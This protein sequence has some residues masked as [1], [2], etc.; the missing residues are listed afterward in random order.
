MKK[1]IWVFVLALCMLFSFG[2][3][4]QAEE[5]G[6]VVLDHAN[7]GVEGIDWVALMDEEDFQPATC[8][9]DGFI[10]KHCSVCGVYVQNEVLPKMEHVYVEDPAVA[11]TC[12][13]T[14]LT[15]GK[16]CHNEILDAE[17]N[18]IGTCGAL[19]KPE[20]AQEVVPALGH[21]PVAA[22]PNWKPENFDCEEGFSTSAVCDVCGEE[23]AEAIF[24][25]FEHQP[26]VLEAVEPTCTSTGLTEG[27]YCTVCGK[28]L[29]E[30]EEIEMLEHDWVFVP[31]TAGSCT[32]DA[33]SY[34][35]ECSVCGAKDKDYTVLPAPGHKTEIVEGYEATCFEDGLTDGE[36]CTVC[37]EWI[38]EQTV[39]PAHNHENDT[40]WETVLGTP[41]TCTEA[42]I[43]AHRRCSLCG[44][45][46][47]NG[48]EFEGDKAAEAVIIP[49]HG[50]V[51]EDGYENA[52]AVGKPAQRREGDA[53]LLVKTNPDDE[54]EATC[55][56][57]G[58]VS[59]LE[60][61]W[62]GAERVPAEE[63]EAT[64]H[65]WVKIQ[66]GI[67][68]TCTEA[69]VSDLWECE[70]CGEQH[71]NEPVNPRGHDMVTVAGQ[72]ATCEE[73]GNY[74]YAY[75]DRVGCCYAE[76]TELDVGIM[77]DIPAF[78]VEKDEDNK[79]IEHPAAVVIPAHNH[80]YAADVTEYTFEGSTVVAKIAPV[81]P[82]CN[83]TGLSDNGF[84]C[85]LCG[86]VLVPADV[87][88]T[89]EHNWV[90]VPAVD[91]TCYA[92]GNLHFM[93]CAY[94]GCTL[95][96]ILNEDGDQVDEL[97]VT[98][99]EENVCEEYP[100]EVILPAFN[101]KD[102]KPGT[103]KAPTCTEAGWTDGLYCT[104]C[105]FPLEAQEEIPALG[106]TEEEIPAVAPTCTETGLTAGV[107]CTVCEEILVEQEEVPALGHT[108]DEYRPAVAPTCTSVGY[109][110][111]LCCSVCEPDYVA[112]T[113]W[114]IFPEEIPMLEHE[115][116]YE[117]NLTADPTCEEDGYDNY[118]YC[119]N[120]DYV[121]GEIIPAL[122]HDWLTFDEEA[123]TC[124]E[125]GVISARTCSVCGYTQPQQKVDPL[126]HNPVVVPGKAA[127]CTETG[128]TDGEK[129]DRCGLVSVEQEEIPALGH[130]MVHVDAVEPTCEAAG[131]KEGQ[132][133]SNEGCDYKIGCETIE[134]LAHTLGDWVVEIQP[135]V[136]ADGQGLKVKYCLTCGHKIEA[137]M[138]P[139]LS[140][141]QLG[142]ANNDGAVNIIDVLVILQHCSEIPVGS[143]NE[144]QAD[145]NEDGVVNVLD[146]LAL[147]YAV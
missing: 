27:S 81:A 51:D 83:K 132:K 145:Y 109:T 118:N 42:G 49:A 102:T 80:G 15:A 46:E 108:Y 134:K 91:A 88:D 53:S 26:E 116:F 65:K 34:H 123:P 96:V 8:E 95:G 105:G 121:E 119:V 57:A 133:C 41:A 93:Y 90:D 98:K 135:S 38:V 31:A 4:A 2:L 18:V 111:G 131:N 78:T 40:A 56:E 137:E 48:S 144:L 52:P 94:E 74:E 14:G 47:F 99:N 29:V 13:E 32:E 22:D 127:T 86:E 89:L 55:T 30:Q 139:A 3:I 114:L 75:C 62:C 97:V 28:I 71:G 130:N 104:I 128:L 136:G 141:G 36:Q 7:C 147:L 87:L 54:K 79:V 69:G 12:T 110:E 122:G 64:G 70:Y 77:A 9:E 5:T 100:A 112:V 106:H 76:V 61:P 58:Y 20:D 140:M 1:Q 142:D 21:T 19:E 117:E 143:F 129:C 67:V 66:T 101:H 68:P 6:D 113:G 85:T 120:C 17:G 125:Y 43:A 73:A 16:S 35:Q 25:T 11:P 126:G 84:L 92:D 115:M 146:A 37:G 103:G 124:T 23:L 63:P 82:T 107:W 24:V 39:I 50:H 44:T 138:I 59:A 60:C 10:R 33:V 72:L 45:V